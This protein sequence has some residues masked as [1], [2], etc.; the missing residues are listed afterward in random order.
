MPLSECCLENTLIIN[1]IADR[2]AKYRMNFIAIPVSSSC[3]PT[4][5]W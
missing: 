5:G 1:V 2:V 4:I 3:I